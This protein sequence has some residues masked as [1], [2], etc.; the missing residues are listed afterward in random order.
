MPNDLWLS[1]SEREI[2]FEVEPRNYIALR[3]TSVRLGLFC[4]QRYCSASAL[5]FS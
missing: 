2:A 4:R 3:A 1:P 5:N